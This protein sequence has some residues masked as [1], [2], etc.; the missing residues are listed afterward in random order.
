[1]NVKYWH[2]ANAGTNQSVATAKIINSLQIVTKNVANM[3]ISRGQRMI[4]T[5]KIT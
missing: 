5:F 4:K 2:S 3:M 1:M